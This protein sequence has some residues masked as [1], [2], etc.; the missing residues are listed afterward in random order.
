MS[1]ATQSQ[2]PVLETPVDGISLPVFVRRVR[3]ADEPLAFNHG[4]VYAYTADKKFVISTPNMTFIP[5]P[6]YGMLNI[7]MMPDA[8]FGAADPLQWPQ[9]F[10]HGTK[11]PWLCVIQRKPK[12]PNDSRYCMWEPLRRS[13]FVPLASSAV[14]GLGTVSATLYERLR[15]RC[16]EAASFKKALFHRYG[17]L[18]GLYWL[19]T[20]M[21]QTLA[22]LQHP[23]TFRDMVR[24]HACVQRF[25]LYTVAWLDW[26]VLHT[27]VYLLEG[28]IHYAR[29]PLNEMMGCITTSPNIAQHFFEVGA[30]VWFMR[31]LDSLSPSDVMQEQVAI[32]PPVAHLDFASDDEK[33]AYTQL[34]AGV[35][36]C[37]IY[38][39]DRHI[40]WIHRQ[41]QQY[42]DIERLPMVDPNSGAVQ[43]FGASTSA[44]LP[45]PPASAS[46]MATR[47]PPYNAKQRFHPYQAPILKKSL[48][49][50]SERQKFQDPDHPVVPPI[51]G[52]WRAASAAVE[53][54]QEVPRG[55][56]V[57]KY[58]VPE[59]RLVVGTD[60]P[61]R[62]KRYVLRWLRI[63]DAWYYLI[64]RHLDYGEALHPLK[65]PQWRDY[66]NMSSLV[67]KDID[68]APDN[69]R[70]KQI[71]AV[72][73]TFAQ[74]LGD[75]SPDESV[76]AKWFNV[77]VESLDESAWR[78]VLRQVAW[79]VAEVGFRVELTELDRYLVPRSAPGDDRERIERDALLARVFPA[80]RGLILKDFPTAT[81]GL[82]ATH[83]DKRSAYLEALRQVLSRWPGAPD[84]M[85]SC[86]ALTSSNS[87]IFVAQMEREM[88]D[89][90]CATFFRVA[91]RAPVLPRC[92]PFS[93]LTNIDAPTG[94]ETAVIAPN[95]SVSVPNASGSAPITMSRPSVSGDAA[96]DGI[97]DIGV[98]PI[99][100]ESDIAPGISGNDSVPDGTHIIV[101]SETPA[102]AQDAAVPQVSGGPDDL[103]DAA[104]RALICDD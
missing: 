58:W 98:P 56:A 30:P 41:A 53:L 45:Q 28:D 79:D 55:D 68:L 14:R 42:G 71:V 102:D 49:T 69:K 90:Y 88:A 76:V 93:P 44:T 34:M 19:C 84:N 103:D 75:S 23:A 39:G 61:E 25:W 35:V 82:E 20:T 83:L 80:N 100:D 15:V 2:N 8:R 52:I 12:S 89:Y 29:M 33:A 91:G 48:L 97:Q 63:R 92:L 6:V 40:E 73:D 37:T 16:E 62:L 46:S 101:D 38:A 66:L 74:L 72:L 60:A 1:D 64:S 9:V 27:R 32:V 22:R 96:T 95:D 50:P 17:Q 86:P 7:S 18:D 57:W 77:D 65:A 67:Q 87:T 54:K 3:D 5:Q 78:R 13:D 47:Q 99:V 94:P 21:E 11:Y 26:H 59:A 43:S 10:E 31:T 85:K 36:G 104:M 70:S 24:Q 51:L 81:D 4:R